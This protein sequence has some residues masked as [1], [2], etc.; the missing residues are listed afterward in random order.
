MLKSSNLTKIGYNDSVWVLM[1]NLFPLL[2][3][4]FLFFFNLSLLK[5]ILT[6]L[7]T[8]IHF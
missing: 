3:A 6:L 8:F 5:Y 4:N 1:L 2:L 7:N